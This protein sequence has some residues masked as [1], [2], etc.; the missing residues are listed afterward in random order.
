MREIYEVY[1]KVVD[2]NGTFNTLTGY[3][4]AFDSRAYDND[5]EKTRQRAYG[6]YHEC[7]GAMCKIDT[8]QIQ[9]A[10]IIRISDGMVIEST[11]MGAFIDDETQEETEE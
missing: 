5:I 11:T 10:M 4:K 8:R 1:A 3:P 2:A 7:L 6:A 9:L